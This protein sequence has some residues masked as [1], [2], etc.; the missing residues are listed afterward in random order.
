MAKREPKDLLTRLADR[1]EEAIQRLSDAPGA[2][3]LLGVA[4]SLR[5]RMD[6]LQRRMRGLDELE[7]RVAELERRVDELSAP[8]A[9]SGRSRGRSSGTKKTSGTRRSGS[10]S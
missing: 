10:Q 1:G 9:A 6:E 4:Q 7:R 3:R 2:D 5:D 8:S